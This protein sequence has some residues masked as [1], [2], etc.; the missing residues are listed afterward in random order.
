[1]AKRVTGHVHHAQLQSCGTFM[2]VWTM[3]HPIINQVQ[4][5]QWN[6]MEVPSSSRLST[7]I[8]MK[9]TVPFN[10]KAWVWPL[11]WNARTLKIVC[12]TRCRRSSI[13]HYGLMESKNKEQKLCTTYQS[14]IVHGL[15]IYAILVASNLSFMWNLPILYKY[16]SLVWLGS[17]R[18]SKLVQVCNN[19]GVGGC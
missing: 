2:K 8:S 9:D 13:Y 19:V 14:S 15:N 1:M 17:S 16:A 10:F 12:T 5:T 4:L 11:N 6:F 3:N 7:Y 18:S